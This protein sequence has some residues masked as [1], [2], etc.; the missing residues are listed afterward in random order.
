MIRAIYSVKSYK[1]TLLA[2]A[3]ALL[4]PGVG[5]DHPDD[6]FPANNFAIFAELFN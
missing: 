3:L 6:A 1:V 5:A 4:M 2:S